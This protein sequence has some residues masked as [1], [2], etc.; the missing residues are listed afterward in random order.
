MNCKAG[1]LLEFEDGSG[2]AENLEENSAAIILFGDG[3][4]ISEGQKV[5]RTGRVVSVPVGEEL[6]GRI[7]DGLGAPIDGKRTDKGKGIPGY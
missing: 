5:K 6:L 4:K 3:R 2:M 1:E 7:V